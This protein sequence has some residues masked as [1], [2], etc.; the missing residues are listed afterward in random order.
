VKGLLSQSS[1]AGIIHGEDTPS[2]PL[3]PASEVSKPSSLAGAG[4]V[5]P[6]CK[7]VKGQV[8]VTLGM[9][10]LPSTTSLGNASFEDRFAMA[11]GGKVWER[12]AV[13]QNLQ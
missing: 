3:L 11:L 8:S 5:H 1:S 9:T 4:H 2:L 10:S 12:S 13:F 6:L 7:Q